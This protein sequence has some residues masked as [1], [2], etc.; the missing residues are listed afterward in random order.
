MK[1][2]RE[3]IKKHVTKIINYE[4]EEILRLTDEEIESFN[5]QRHI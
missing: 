4:Q 3:D 1:R 5:N 2:F